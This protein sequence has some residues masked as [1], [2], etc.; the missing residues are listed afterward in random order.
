MIACAE[1]IAT[2]LGSKVKI[3]KLNI[4]EILSSRRSSACARSR[5]S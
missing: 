1:E 4:D 3:A 2:E 5:R